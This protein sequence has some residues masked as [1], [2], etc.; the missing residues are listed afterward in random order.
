MKWTCNMEYET[1]MQCATWNMKC[2]QNM[3]YE[4]YMEYEI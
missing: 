1:D 2:I 3:E 4:M